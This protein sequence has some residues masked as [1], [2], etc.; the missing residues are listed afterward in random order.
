MKSLKLGSTVFDDLFI[1]ETSRSGKDRIMR[2]KVVPEALAILKEIIEISL[3]RIYDF[4]LNY[5]ILTRNFYIFPR[6]KIIL[7]PYFSRNYN[8][9]F[10]PPK[11]N[12][13]LNSLS[14]NFLPKVFGIP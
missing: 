3:L 5:I 4:Y 13:F 7:F 2:Y 8:L 1:K 14:I 10:L 11:L 9:P 12:N 6:Y